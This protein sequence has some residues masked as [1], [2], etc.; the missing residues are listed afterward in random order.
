MGVWGRQPPQ[1]HGPLRLRPRGRRCAW[2]SRPCLAPA[3]LCRTAKS[4]WEEQSGFLSSREPGSPRPHIRAQRGEQLSSPRLRPV[5]IRAGDKKDR[6][7]HGQELH[8]K[9]DCSK[10]S[11]FSTPA[12]QECGR[13]S[14]GPALTSRQ[15]GLRWRGRPTS[16]RL[17]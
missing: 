15:V 2:L 6:K 5:S 9:C 16:G 17:H 11:D 10:Q 12:R 1:L 13:A 3:M 4:I 8:L 14:S 7:R